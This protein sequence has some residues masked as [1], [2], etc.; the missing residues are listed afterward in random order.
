MGKNMIEEELFGI[1]GFNITVTELREA[2]SNVPD[3]AEIEIQGGEDDGYARL[4][5]TILRKE[6]DDEYKAR[7]ALEASDRARNELASRREYE[8]LKAKYEP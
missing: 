6:T 3:D 5:C 2:L 1:Y 8:R 7:S 4:I